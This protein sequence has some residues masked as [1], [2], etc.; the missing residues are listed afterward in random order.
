MIFKSSV[1]ILKIFYYYITYQFLASQEHLGHHGLVLVWIIM[2]L[3]LQN[4]VLWS[5][6]KHGKLYNRFICKSWYNYSDPAPIS[7]NHKD[8]VPNG[9][10]KWHEETFSS[11]GSTRAYRGITHA[12]LSLL[13]PGIV[14]LKTIAW[15][16][17]WKFRRF[18]NIWTTIYMA[19]FIK[20]EKI[21]M[22][23]NSISSWRFLLVVFFKVLVVDSE[24][25]QSKNG[26]TMKLM[27]NSPKS[28]FI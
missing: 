27:E 24:I 25:K 9:Q 1:W 4:M 15:S 8:L 26:Q 22:D 3:H 19:V 28:C 13:D 23:A 6:Y 7:T 17:Y 18:E 2:Y 12:R 21:S 5:L 16:P 20:W 11:T 10:Q 14:Q